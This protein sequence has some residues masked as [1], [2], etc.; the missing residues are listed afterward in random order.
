[1]KQAS[2]SVFVEKNV[3]F[4]GQSLVKHEKCDDVF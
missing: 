2:M 1:M 4:S 3:V